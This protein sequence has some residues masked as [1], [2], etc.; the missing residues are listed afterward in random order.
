HAQYLLAGT[1]TGRMSCR[2]P[3]LQNV[4]RDP[5]FREC[6][7]AAE[8]H[9]LVVADYAQA[10]LRVVAVLANEPALL[11]AFNRGVDVHA[12]TAA[13]LLKKP[14]EEI[15]KAERQRAKACSFGFLYGQ[16]VA[17]FVRY[18]R[19]TYGVTLTEAEA[20]KLRAGWF[21]TYPLL[22][23]WQERQLEDAKRLGTTRTPSGRVR[24]LEGAKPGSP[25]CTPPQ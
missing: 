14:I 6:F 1:V 11:D 21:N 10:E 22:R 4:P 24:S 8:G 3:N 19:A 15:T 13:R 25:L 18:A 12:A 23:A 16:G 7:R 2:D 9:A 5:A 17:G 20:R